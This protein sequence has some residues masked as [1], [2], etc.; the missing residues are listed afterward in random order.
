MDKQTLINIQTTLQERGLT[1]WLFYDYKRS[2]DLA[3]NL[4]QIPDNQMFT[5]RWFY[6]I[7]ARGECVKIVSAV[8]RHSLDSLPGK[9]AVY[10]TWR[11][12]EMI[13]KEFLAEGATIAMEYSPGNRIPSLSKVDAGTMEMIREKGAKVVSSGDLLQLFTSVWDKEEIDSHLY[14]QKVLIEAVDAAWNI[15]SEMLRQGISITEY[16]VQ[17]FI[18][19]QFDQRGCTTDAPPIVAVNAHSA[20]PHYTPSSESNTLIQKGDFV[21]IDLWCKKLGTKNCYADICRVA[22]AREKPTKREQ[23]VFAIVRSA[24]KKATEYVIQAFS[25]K[26]PITGAEVDRVCRGVIEK[27]GYGE[28]FIHRTG[29]NIGQLDHGSGAHI[30][31]FETEDTRRLLLGTC[32]SIEPGIYLPQEFGIRLEYDLLIHHDGKVQITGGIQESIKTLV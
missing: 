22:V 19:E 9:N 14:A 32:F 12:M 2:N 8:E 5:R 21:L 3:L 31:S 13:L 4:L 25:S 6:W 23:E 10:R 11:Q 7:P 17:Q 29:H 1:G 28:F 26:K 18:L 30:D 27:S 15:I 20:D 24:Q 16:E